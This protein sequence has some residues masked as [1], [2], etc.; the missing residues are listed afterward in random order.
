MPKRIVFI[1]HAQSKANANEI[2]EPSELINCRITDHGKIQSSKINFSFDLLILSP[3][4]RALETYVHSDIKVKNV[5]I[6]DLFQE[7]RVGETNMLDNVD[8]SKLETFEELENRAID[9]WK[10]LSSIPIDNIGIISHH[11]FTKVFFK[12]IFNLD[13]S[14][15]NGQAFFVELTEK[16]PDEQKVVKDL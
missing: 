1:R 8:H 12:K 9:A 7:F 15:D 10:F 5:I 2:T 14:L 16:S 3:L 11:D 4:K 13:V 6:S